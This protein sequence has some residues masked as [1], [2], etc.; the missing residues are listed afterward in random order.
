MPHVRFDY[1]KALGFFRE[2]ELTYL[3]DM[4][5]V[6]HHSLHEKTGTGSD[7]LGCCRN[8]RKGKNRKSYSYHYWRGCQDA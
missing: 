3:R 7:F 8:R 1:S 4:V 6:A 5:K 2:H